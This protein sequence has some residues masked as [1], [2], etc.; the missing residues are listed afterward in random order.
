MFINH[1]ITVEKIKVNNE[2]IYELEY[3]EIGPFEMPEPK[4][5]KKIKQ[6]LQN[7]SSMDISSRWWM[8]FSSWEDFHGLL[9]S[10]TKLSMHLVVMELKTRLNTI[11]DGYCHIENIDQNGNIILDLNERFPTLMKHYQ[12]IA[13]RR[14]LR[15]LKQIASYN[16]TK[17]ISSQYEIQQ[18]DIPQSLNNFVA[19]FLD[20][21]DIDY[22]MM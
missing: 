4:H 2:M 3:P 21:Y 5:L 10:G 8:D 1:Y 15:T 20:A 13:R 11:T 12:I 17:Y 14:K 6:A 7:I 22:A 19:T 18:L 9:R 16:I